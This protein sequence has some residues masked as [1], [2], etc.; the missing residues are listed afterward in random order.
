MI[1]TIQIDQRFCDFC[2]KEAYPWTVCL[3]CG[4]DLCP[5]IGVE[6]KPHVIRYP[7]S[8][9]CSGSNDGY[10]C[11]PCD[12]QLSETRSDPLHQ[13]YVAIKDYRDEEQRVYKTRQANG[14][15]LEQDVMRLRTERGLR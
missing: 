7:H 14:E 3:G 1:K 8:V 12:V 5:P 4:K 13:A 15:R 11:V 2:N 9:N 6:A 10:Y